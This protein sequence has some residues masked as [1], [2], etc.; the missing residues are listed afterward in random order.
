MEVSVARVDGERRAAR[1]LVE[2]VRLQRGGGERAAPV[3]RNVPEVGARKEYVAVSP[4]CQ[5]KD[6]GLPV[7]LQRER[8]ARVLYLNAEP[9]AQLFD[10]LSDF[11]VLQTTFMD[12]VR[13]EAGYKS[14][15]VGRRRGRPRKNPESDLVVTK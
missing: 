8:A 13:R 1:P 10:Q 6:D 11:A 15:K 9:C 3:R 12:V 14:V 2:E 4:P 7:D 5:L